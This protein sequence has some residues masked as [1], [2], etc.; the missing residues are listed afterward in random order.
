MLR[1]P[2]QKQSVQTAA[3][4]NILCQSRD[5]GPP[6]GQKEPNNVKQKEESY[7]GETDSTHFAS[8]Q[9]RSSR[10]KGESGEKRLAKARVPP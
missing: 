8:R 5:T 2:F 9:K 6:A 7:P 10:E 1:D 3:N 4:P